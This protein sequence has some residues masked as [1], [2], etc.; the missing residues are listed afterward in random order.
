MSRQDRRNPPRFPKEVGILL[1]D[2]RTPAI[3]FLK[4]RSVE[5]DVIVEPTA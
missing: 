1:G 3:V 4:A 5:E 2:F